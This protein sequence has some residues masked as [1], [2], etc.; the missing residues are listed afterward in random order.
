MGLVDVVTSADALEP[1]VRAHARSLARPSPGAIGALKRFCADLT[2]PEG[3]AVL[4]RGG[5][6][7]RTLLQNEQVGQAIRDFMAGGRLPWEAR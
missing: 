2:S 1:T 6:M 4:A 3:R 7:T 5:E